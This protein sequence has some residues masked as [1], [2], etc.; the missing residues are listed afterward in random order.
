MVDGV[1]TWQEV[2][3]RLPPE[4]VAAIIAE[5]WPVRA[6]QAVRAWWFRPR[7]SAAVI[8]STGESFARDI[9]TMLGE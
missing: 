8:A 1:V 2:A 3:D 6:R 9:R 7:G 4:I 5:P